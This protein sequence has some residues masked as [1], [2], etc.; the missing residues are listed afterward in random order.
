VDAVES[1]LVYL[2]GGVEAIDAQCRARTLRNPPSHQLYPSPN[3][4]ESW[5]L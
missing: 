4:L 3:T 5:I 1:E 2:R